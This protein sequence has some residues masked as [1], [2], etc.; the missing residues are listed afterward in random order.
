MAK[1]SYRQIIAWAMYD[2]ANSAFATTVMAGFFPIFFKQFWSAGTDTALSTARLGMANSLAGIAVALAAPFLG[3]I[4]DRSAGKKA[5]LFSFAALGIIS[6]ISLFHVAMGSWVM[7]TVL[8]AL[9]ITGFSGG[10]VFYDS[11]LKTIVP[12]SR[13]DSVSSLGYALGYL[14]G[15]LLFALNV[16]MVLEPS[17]FGLGDASEAV[18][19]SFIT[20][21]IWWTIFALPL[22]FLVH[23]KRTRRKTRPLQ[24]IAEGVLQLR[25]TISKIRKMRNLS[26]F[27]LAYWLYIDG[28]DTIIVMAV[29]YGLS[30][31]FRQEDLISALL[32]VQ[33]VGF[34][35]AIAFGSIAGRLGTKRSILVG[36]CI[37]LFVAIWGALIKNRTEFYVM[38]ILIGMV[39]G[40][41]QALSRSFF[42]KLIP[43]DKAAQYFG[44]YNLLGK[45]AAIIGPILV[46]ASVVMSRSLGLSPSISS[47]LSISSIAILFIAGGL[48]LQLVD[49]EKGKYEAAYEY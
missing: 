31:G 24:M 30:L 14:G 28:V 45:F 22:A 20:V 17:F 40:G 33:F 26:L 9:A 23:E 41:V 47:R 4:A 19:L 39:Q 1:G 3:A 49:E 11:L 16:L 6:T 10:N 12:E 43:E 2:W 13:M 25:H 27:L 38:A 46:G 21:G 48:L 8:Y 35:C 18:R 36:I 34:P 32:L 5:F 44:F 37:Y 7:A 15:G 42:A 29:D